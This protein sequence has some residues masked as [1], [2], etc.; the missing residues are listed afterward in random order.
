M[1]G[2]KGSGRKYSSHSR[3]RTTS[4]YISKMHFDLFVP[5]KYF[6]AKITTIVSGA[7]EGKDLEPEEEGTMK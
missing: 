3:R 4:N 2:Q 7:F 5:I 6:V 1:T